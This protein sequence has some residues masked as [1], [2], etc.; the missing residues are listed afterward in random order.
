MIFDSLVPCSRLILAV[1]LPVAPAPAECASSTITL[2]PA[3]A[4]ST[5]VT[6]PVI[7][8]PTTTTSAWRSASS[9]GLGGDGR[10][11]RS[12]SHNE[13]M[14]S[15]STLRGGDETRALKSMLAE[16]CSNGLLTEC[17]SG[18]S[19]QRRYGVGRYERPLGVVGRDNEPGRGACRQSTC[20]APLDADP[21]AIGRHDHRL[22][23]T[24]R[25]PGP[26]GDPRRDQLPR[27]TASGRSARRDGAGGR[28]AVVRRR[29]RGSGALEPDDDMGIPQRAGQQHD[30]CRRP[31]SRFG[32]SPTPSPR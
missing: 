2:L 32:W 28:R 31:A 4:N 30:A 5:A 13:V 20:D 25:G 14:A 29:D 22:R 23:R 6:S 3:L 10:F 8:A 1:V 27:R 16:R 21:R 24:R 11:A 19:P 26:A 17:L 7:P 9:N 15:R 12:A 18:I